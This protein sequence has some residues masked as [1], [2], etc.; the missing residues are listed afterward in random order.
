MKLYPST[1]TATHDYQSPSD[2]RLCVKNETPVHC[3]NRDIRFPMVWEVE[4]HPMNHGTSA[5]KIW[6]ILMDTSK[7]ARRVRSEFESTLP[8]PLGPDALMKD[9]GKHLF[10]RHEVC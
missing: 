6:V 10:K 1:R 2:K 3:E 4:D 7:D 5:K 9:F 8:T